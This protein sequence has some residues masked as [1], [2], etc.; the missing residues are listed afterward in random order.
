MHIF[1]TL[2]LLNMVR[3][4]K[5]I[6]ILSM[7]IKAAR[8]DLF[9]TGVIF[10]IA[11]SAYVQLIYILFNYK[12]SSFSTIVK[13]FE[14]SF[15]MMMGRSSVDLYDGEDRAMGSVI[16]FGFKV[17]IVFTILNIFVSILSMSYFKIKNENLENIQN[18]E[19]LLI[20]FMKEEISWYYRKLT[21]FTKKE[22]IVEVKEEYKESLDLIDKRIEAVITMVNHAIE[23]HALSNHH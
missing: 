10:F 8:V 11:W 5:T 12:K 22:T 9:G 20:E 21:N 7:S 6:K 23:K 14:S 13:T 4:Y 3:F 1:A 17:M 16:S 2:K 15:L 19:E 18:D